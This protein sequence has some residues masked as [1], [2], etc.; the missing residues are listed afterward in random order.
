MEAKKEGQKFH[1]CLYSRFLSSLSPTESYRWRKRLLKERSFY[2]FVFP[3]SL[4]HLSFPFFPLSLSKH[5]LSPFLN[6]IHTQS[7]HHVRFLCSSQVR[8]IGNRLFS[9]CLCRSIFNPTKRQVR[10]TSHSFSF[11]TSRKGSSYTPSRIPNPFG[12]C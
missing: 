5:I 11:P 3:P 6:F 7:L 12:P 4:L 9:S 10:P 2:R 8:L 1:R